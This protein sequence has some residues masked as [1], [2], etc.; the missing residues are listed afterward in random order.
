MGIYKIEILKKITIQEAEQLAV[1]YNELMPQSIQRAETILDI[2]EKMLR[3]KEHFLICARK[4]EE[5]IGTV[6]AVCCNTLAMNGK[7]FLI[8]EDFVVKENYRNLGIG[9][10]LLKY[11]EVLAEEENCWATM[12]LSSESRKD[13]H[14]FY[15]SNGFDDP[16]KGFRRITEKG[17]DE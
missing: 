12:L 10:E 3:K 15:Q 6:L 8:L 1:L 11:T 7:K 16:V 5:I 9:K 13:A 14:R 4:Q 2:S 17:V